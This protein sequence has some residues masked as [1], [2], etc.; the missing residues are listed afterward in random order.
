MCMKQELYCT[1]YVVVYATVRVC[2]Y[3][4]VVVDE[5]SIG[6]QPISLHVH[7]FQ[8]KMSSVYSPYRVIYLH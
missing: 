7:L 2:E 4:I 5:Y 6:S 8:H 3:T 1:G